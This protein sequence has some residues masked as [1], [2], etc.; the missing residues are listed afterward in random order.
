M[1]TNAI[2]RAAGLSLAALCLSVFPVANVKGQDVGVDPGGG[3][4]RAKNPETKK[5][6]TGT[7]PTNRSTGQHRRDRTNWKND[8]IG[9]SRSPGTWR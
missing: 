6:A 9:F 4:F 3:L 1:S 7:K 5:P 8:E 2:L